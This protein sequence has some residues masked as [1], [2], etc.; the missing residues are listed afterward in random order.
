MLLSVICVVL[1][2]ATL[3]TFCSIKIYQASYTNSNSISGKPFRENLVITLGYNIEFFII[4]GLLLDLYK[5]WLFIALT[6]ETGFS[7]K[8]IEEKEKQV[9]KQKIQIY[10]IFL[11]I[12]CM[13]IITF[14]TLETLFL[15]FSPTA[16]PKT[17]E[18]I[19]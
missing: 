12:A 16:P 9:L 7:I 4:L 13:F 6:K 19:E 3:V 8:H 1:T 14:G 15:V 5:W 17:E 11:T 2:L 10:Y 18:R